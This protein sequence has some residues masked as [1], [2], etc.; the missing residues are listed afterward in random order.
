MKSPWDRTDTQGS[1]KALSLPRPPSAESEVGWGGVQIC[2]IL[3]EGKDVVCRVEV[4]S[5]SAWLELCPHP[6]QG[7]VSGYVC[8]APA[9]QG[10]T[11]GVGCVS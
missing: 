8:Q 3:G 9:G 1:C 7:D 10:V 2:G 5:A 4:V 11:P 6:Q